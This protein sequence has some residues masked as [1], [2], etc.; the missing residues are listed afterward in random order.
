MSLRG[1]PHSDFVACTLC[2]FQRAQELYDTSFHPENRKWLSENNERAPLTRNTKARGTE[3]APASVLPRGTPMVG[4][5]LL[6]QGVTPPLPLLWSSVDNSHAL[7]D[8]DVSE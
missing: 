5:L 2:S 3:E 6:L 4:P 7:S 1:P 8:I